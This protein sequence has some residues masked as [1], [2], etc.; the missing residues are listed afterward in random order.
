MQSVTFF[1]VLFCSILF[2]S[3]GQYRNYT[4]QYAQTMAA[5]KITL[6]EQVES[7]PDTNLLFF[8]DRALLPDDSYNFNYPLSADYRIGILIDPC[9]FNA[10][11]CCLNTFGTAEYPALLKSK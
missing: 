5:N 4:A 1:V 11:N 9:R 7:H 8:P 10:Y 2:V 6:T 3:H